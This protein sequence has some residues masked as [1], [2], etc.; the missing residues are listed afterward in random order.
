MTV[1]CP[2]CRTQYRV[3]DSR[4]SDENPVFKCTRCENVFAPGEEKRAARRK[5]KE[6]AAKPPNLSFGFDEDSDEAAG[7]RAPRHAAASGE[8]EEPAFLGGLDDEEEEAGFGD[9]DSPLPEPSWNEEVEE[10]REDE[11]ETEYQDE[12]YEEDF[13]ELPDE[14][15]DW[16]PEPEAKPRSPRRPKKAAVRPRGLRARPAATDER[17]RRSPLR[18]V[19]GTVA[20][21]CLTYLLI[22]GTFARRPDVAMDVLTRIP[23]LGNLLGQDHLLAWRLELR[24]VRGGLDHIKGNRLAYVVTGRAVNTTSQNIRLV[25]IEGELIAGGK[26]RSKRRVYAANQ[27]KRTIRDLSMS[28]VDMLLR[29]E[30]NRRFVIRPG[31]SASFLLVFPDPP[32]DTS[33]VLCRVV[34]ARAS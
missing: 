8:S 19:G 22:A 33:E 15:D 11:E 18:P 14:D 30:P 31:E 5:R 2:R 12:A 24:D 29:L 20:L 9:A 7:G 25:E 34:D 32:A 1:Q 26:S 21:L 4:L 6:A 23:I 13:S 27:A 3:P 16:D 10:G 28:E 17:P